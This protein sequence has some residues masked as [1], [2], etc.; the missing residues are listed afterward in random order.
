MV[1]AA[2]A[3]DARPV[4]SGVYFHSAGGQAVVAATDSYRLAENKMAKV[5][6]PINFL[7]PA[8]A[9]PRICCA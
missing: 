8:T 7:V 6:K 5:S 9:P 2:S 4:L 1:F 3:D